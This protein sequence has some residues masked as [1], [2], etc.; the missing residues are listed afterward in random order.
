M[1]SSEAL[2]QEDKA[3]RYFLT[4]LDEIVESGQYLAAKD[5]PEK[6]FRP[7]ISIFN[8]NYPGGLLDKDISRS[9]SGII[10]AGREKG[11]S[12]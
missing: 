5:V 3:T 8:V 7:I 9:A 11:S 1:Y 6:G 10:K 12:A 2:A 4:I